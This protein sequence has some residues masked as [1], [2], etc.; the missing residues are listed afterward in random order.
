MV[1]SS[2]MWFATE[3]RTRETSCNERMM[4]VQLIFHDV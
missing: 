4:F 1:T 3:R 2:R